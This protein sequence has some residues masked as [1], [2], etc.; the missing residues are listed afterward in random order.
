MLERG[1]LTFVD[2]RGQFDPQDKFTAR[3]GDDTVQLTSDSII[4]GLARAHAAARIPSNKGPAGIGAQLPPSL[5]RLSF[6]EKIAGA[7][8]TL[9]IEP[10]MEQPGSTTSCSVR[11]ARSGIRT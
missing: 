3:R 2:N 6:S 8:P 5:D 1:P 4:F 10:Q 11:I 7:N 9:K